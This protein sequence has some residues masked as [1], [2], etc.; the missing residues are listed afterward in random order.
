MTHREVRIKN[1]S[2]LTLGQ[3]KFSL[4]YIYN[5][6]GRASQVVVSW[7]ILVE[8]LVDAKETEEVNR[9]FGGGSSPL[10]CQNRVLGC[11]FCS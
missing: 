4:E 1:I 8:T 6:V 7:A 5:G 3:I 10:C 2:N 11:W 9:D